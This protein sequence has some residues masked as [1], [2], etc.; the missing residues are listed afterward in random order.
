MFAIK[1]SIK[2]LQGQYCA[3]LFTLLFNSRECLNK[4]ITKN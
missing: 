4:S 3:I 2:A 1:K